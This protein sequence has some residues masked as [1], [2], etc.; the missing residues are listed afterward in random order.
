MVFRDRAIAADRL[1]VRNICLGA[2]PLLFRDKQQ[3]RLITVGHRGSTFL[4]I[5]GPPQLG[6]GCLGRLG[7]LGQVPDPSLTESRRRG[8]V[9]IP[10]AAAGQIVRRDQAAADRGSP[11]TR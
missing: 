10:G 9:T 2:R 11:V 1:L 6:P 3:K 7:M 4:S 5:M 8:A